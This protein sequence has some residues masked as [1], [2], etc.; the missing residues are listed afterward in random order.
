MLCVVGFVRLG[1][2]YKWSC[3]L[4]R[5]GDASDQFSGALIGYFALHLICSAND[6]G[7]FLGQKTN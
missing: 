7:H 3:V 5:F 1:V 6:H 2:V 4:Q